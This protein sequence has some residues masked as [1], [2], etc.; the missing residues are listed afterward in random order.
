MHARNK[1]K[2]ETKNK[3]EKKRKREKQKHKDEDEK[4]KTRKRNKSSERPRRVQTF[5]VYFAANNKSTITPKVNATAA[6]LCKGC[7]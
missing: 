4:Q 2:I 1:G 5:S 7:K 6:R 3:I